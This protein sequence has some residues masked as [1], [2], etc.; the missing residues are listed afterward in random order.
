[1]GEIVVGVDGCE[2]SLDAL[3]LARRLAGPASR[4]LLVCV[5]QATGW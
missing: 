3:A 5:Y 2:R 4:L 1:V